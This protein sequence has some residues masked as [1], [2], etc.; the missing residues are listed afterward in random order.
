MKDFTVLVVDDDEGIRKLLRYFVRKQGYEVIC[1]GT[2]KEGLKEIDKKPAL[3]LL[4]M[5]LPDMFGIT[6]LERMLEKR[7]CTGVI[8]V[9]GVAEHALGIHS[10]EKGAL[11]FVTKPI[12]MEHLGFLIDFHVL[13]SHLEMTG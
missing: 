11:D 12:D 7:P 2:G 3:V 9:T 4:D 5:M 1:A 8:V 6:V 13:R 10:L